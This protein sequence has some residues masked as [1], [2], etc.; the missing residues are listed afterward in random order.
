LGDR[1]EALRLLT[2]YLATNPQ[3]RA[4]LAKD[5]TWWWRG[6]RDDSRFKALVRGG[7]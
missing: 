6:L 4:T 5:D 1:D 3:D 2:V 7:R